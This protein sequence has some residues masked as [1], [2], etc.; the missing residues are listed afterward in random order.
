MTDARRDVVAE[1]DRLA[2][3]YDERWS[4]YVRAT[5]EATA[6]RVVVVPGQRLLDVGCGT[7][8]LLRLLGHQH[9][10]VSLAGIDPSHAMLAIARARLPANVGLMQG[11]AEQ[12]PLADAT[13]DIVVTNSAFHYFADPAAAVRNMKR[14]LRPG[15][16]LVI[17]DWCDDFLVCRL[18]DRWLRLVN[19]VHTRIYTSAEC[20][21]FLE[22]AGLA[23]VEI[24]RYKINWLWGLMTARAGTVVESA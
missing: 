14:V 3:D 18:C 16:K 12:L 20:R 7:G 24:E 8:A 21:G 19:P 23:P 9:P 11:S 4:F 15:G 13:F 17:T 22:S 1:Y 10:R 2:P 5:A 6:R